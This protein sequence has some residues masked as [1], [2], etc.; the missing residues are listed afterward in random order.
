MATIGATIWR[1]AQDVELYRTRLGERR[2]VRLADGSRIHL[3]TASTVEV[4]LREDSRRVRLV[5]GEALFEVAHDRLGRSRRLAKSFENTTTSATGW[6]QVA[7]IA[8]T[9]RHISRERARQR[10]TAARTTITRLG[11]PGPTGRRR[12]SR[13]RGD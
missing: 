7:C 8:T 5:K 4:S 9:L 3:N 10:P 13:T 11:S 2:E 12:R 1:Y 6:L